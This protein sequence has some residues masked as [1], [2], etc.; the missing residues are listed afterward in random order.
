[1]KTWLFVIIVC[2]NFLV[3]KAMAENSPR[4]SSGG[5]SVFENSG[6]KTLVF[7]AKDVGATLPVRGH[8]VKFD[9]DINTF[10][11][12]NYGSNVNPNNLSINSIRM[13]STPFNTVDKKDK[14]IF[15]SDIVVE[16][17]DKNK[18]TINRNGFDLKMIIRALDCEID[19]A[20][21][22]ELIRKTGETTIFVV[23]PNQNPVFY[24]VQETNIHE[25]KTM[26]YK[27]P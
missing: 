13:I 26:T 24:Q 17:S 3:P 20:I 6:I 19:S 22:I 4:C 23:E 27:E 8:F 11:V 10:K 12:T 25:A 15:N 9:V 5:F 16:L 7:A 2:T 1:M 18:I 21:E 14:D